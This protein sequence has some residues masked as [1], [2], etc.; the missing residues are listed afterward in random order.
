MEQYLR[1]TDIIDYGHAAVRAQ[2]AALATGAGT[3]IDVAYRCF[4]FV[5]DRI[6]HTHD[7]R[8]ETITCAA[9][10]VLSFR[11]GFCYAKAHLLAALLRANGI[12]AGFC[13]QRLS[14]DGNGAP[15]CLHGLNAVY[16]DDIGWYRLD[17]RGNTPEVDAQFTPP[18]ECLAW[19][20]T[21]PG[22]ADLP[23]IWPDP[24]P[25]V[26]EALHASLSAEELWQ[27]LPD[28]AIIGR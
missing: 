7:A 22:E 3:A 16:L 18:I 27:R 20:V 9:S 17:A 4:T 15:Y 1:A 24:L 14:R 6:A 13:Y 25:L 12:P 10:E 11:T 26:V 19:P 2:A 28:I 8:G 21:L 5:R 23:E